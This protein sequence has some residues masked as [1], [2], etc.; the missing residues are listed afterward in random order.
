M[1][2]R[3]YGRFNHLV[4]LDVGLASRARCGPCGGSLWR[5]AAVVVQARYGRL[6][7]WRAVNTSIDGLYVSRSQDVHLGVLI[8]CGGTVVALAQCA[9]GVRHR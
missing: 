6:C 8:S 5:S 9:V 4:G 2:T 7:G 1:I 3:V